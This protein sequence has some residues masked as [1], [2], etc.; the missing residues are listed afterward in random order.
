MDNEKIIDCRGISK[1]FDRKGE[2][3]L[4]NLTFE[5][6]KGSI[7]GLMGPDSAGKT[8]LLRLLCGL[9]L[10]D[11]GSLEVLGM[12]VRKKRSRV[13]RTIGYMPQK[14]GLYEDLTVRE[15][16][17]L[18]AE[19]YAVPE[20][21]KETRINKLLQ[22][23]A[24]ERF[25][26]RLAGNLSGGMKQKLGVISVLLSRPP[27]LLLD[28][29]TVGVD[30]LSRRELWD[31]VTQSV[32]EDNLTAIVSTSYMDES[33]YCDKAMIIYRGKLLAWGV[34]GEIAEKAT[35]RVYEE[36]VPDGIPPR[37]MQKKLN[38]GP[39][40]IN[41]SIEG[42]KIR[43]LAFDEVKNPLPPRFED[44]FLL[45]IA[46]HVKLKEEKQKSKAVE[47]TPAVSKIV[48]RPVEVRVKD[49]LKTFGSFTA[50]DH[51]SFEV[52]KGEIFGLLGANGAGKSTTFRML[53]GLMS[54]DG[55]SL[56]VAGVDLRHAPETARQNLGYVAQKFSLYTDLTTRDN[57][58]FFGGA[59]GLTGKKL[60]E[61][62]D[63]ALDNFDLR[64]YD[65]TRTGLLPGGYKQR[66]S[67]ACALLHEP[68]ILFLDELTSGADPMARNDFWG[69]ITGL[70]ESGVTVIITTH[71]LDEAEY[72]DRMIIMADGKMLAGGTP[73]EIRAMA[74]KDNATLEDA[75]LAIIEKGRQNA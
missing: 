64:R 69:R 22:M 8:T 56:E 47:N 65:R 55:G 16:L 28:E 49:L 15:N 62:I 74:Q 43:C 57:L 30:V 20:A 1:R 4:D 71:F 48:E 2:P 40:V 5:I 38:A 68:A 73:D 60:K 35:G 23:A 39:A 70:A 44:G 46:E 51:I 18:Y 21:E 45:Q 34:P 27:L 7:V 3:A 12:D 67:M 14:F 52:K 33:G 36:T 66:L 29:P 17:D 75:F 63:W 54:P 25:P 41:A 31:I 9:Y 50:V 42:R 72:C 32:K 19:V 61:R 53:C 13:Q 58:T 59:Y 10:P 26:D 11:S 24:L 37:I 6:T